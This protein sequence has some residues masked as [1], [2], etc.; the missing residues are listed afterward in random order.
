MVADR[1][2]L[3]E[4]RRSPFYC[5]LSTFIMSFASASPSVRVLI[6]DEQQAEQKLAYGE[7]HLGETIGAY[8]ARLPGFTIK[9]V[10]MDMPEQGLDNATLDDADVLIWWGHRRH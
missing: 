5:L 8:L 10:S 3:H 6:W 7:R 2:K 1:S 4:I 9:C